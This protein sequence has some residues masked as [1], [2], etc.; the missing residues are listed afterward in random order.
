MEHTFRETTGPPE[1]RLDWMRSL[2]VSL[3]ISFF[4][5]Q[6]INLTTFL[7]RR[8]KT[9]R[10]ATQAKRT[11]NEKNGFDFRAVIDQL[12]YFNVE[13]PYDL[14]HWSVNIGTATIAQLRN[15]NFDNV[16]SEWNRSK[17]VNFVN[18]QKHHL[19]E[20]VKNESGVNLWTWNSQMCTN[21]SFWELR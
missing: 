10:A 13:L 15:W 2:Q 19:F 7:S 20:T 4:E 6:H 11:R 5:P 12:F 21:V 16:N 8:R 17:S 18:E 14:A 1:F 9:S 3:K